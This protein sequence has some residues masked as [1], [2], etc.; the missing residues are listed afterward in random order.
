MVYSR[1]LNQL[2]I[3]NKDVLIEMLLKEIEIATKGSRELMEL[4]EIQQDRLKILLAG[5]DRLPVGRQS[6]A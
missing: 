6:G 3:D 1:D 4:T 5:I 2:I